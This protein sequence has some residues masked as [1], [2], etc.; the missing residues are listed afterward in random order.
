MFTE[1][2]VKVN[3]S[4]PL[5]LLAPDGMELEHDVLI[6][7]ASVRCFMLPLV[8]FCAVVFIIT[9]MSYQC[10]QM[11][12]KVNNIPGASFQLMN[13]FVQKHRKCTHTHTV[14]LNLAER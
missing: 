10:K 13:R 5:A 1:K 9:A 12:W 2:S 3:Q 11:H 14:Y 7:A 6:R 8:C 4:L